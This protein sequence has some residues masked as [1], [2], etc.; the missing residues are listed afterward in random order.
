MKSQ[1][2]TG[3][4]LA[5]LGFAAVSAQ[6]FTLGVGV[7]A[8]TETQ[9]SDG[10]RA[11]PLISARADWRDGRY[12]AFEGISGR[13][14]FVPSRAIQAGPVARVRFG[15]DDDVD[16]AAVAALPEIDTTAELGGFLSLGRPAL[17][18][19]VSATIE[20]RHDVGSAHEDYVVDLGVS[21]AWEAS[22]AT[23]FSLGVGTSFAGE[24]YFDT[25]FGVDAAGALAS[26]LPVYNPDAGLLDVSLSVNALHQFNERWSAFGIGRVGQLLGDAADSPITDEGS[27]TSVFVGGALARRF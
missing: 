27:E 23:R 16:S 26:G 14:N 6:E 22:E 13:I 3:L 25:Y 11:I 8:I 17:G 19:V 15:R 10:V 9:G 1:F 5:S 2:A 20:A 7:G 24:D 18:G 12:A 4:A 21:Y